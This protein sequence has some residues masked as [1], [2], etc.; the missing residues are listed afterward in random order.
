MRTK[1]K[2]ES[3]RGRSMMLSR[4]WS[5]A[6]LLTVVIARRRKRNRMRKARETKVL[7]C[8]TDRMYVLSRGC[9][10]T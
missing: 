10:L 5:K 1:R 4:M 6:P 2:S 9:G 8:E 7:P 3:G